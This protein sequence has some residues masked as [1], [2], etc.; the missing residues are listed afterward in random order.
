MRDFTQRRVAAACCIA[1]ALALAGC[2]DDGTAPGG[3]QGF[4][5]AIV[6]DDPTATSPSASG[7]LFAGS[8][9]SEA[10]L[11][12]GSITADLAVAISADGT[13][14]IELGP[15]AAL[16]LTAQAA[17]TTAIHSDAAVPAGSFNRIRLR[18][19][20]ASVE[21]LAG[22]TIGGITIVTD[23]SVSVNGG[24]DVEIIMTVP[25]FEV[26][27]DASVRTEV[28]LDLNSEL[29]ITEEAVQTGTA[30]EGDLEAAIEGDVRAVARSS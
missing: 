30:S 10:A 20:N 18:L 12:S 3:Q 13:T 11:Y 5:S 22:S 21:V 7:P 17:G 24:D 1:L 27:A 8:A 28:F 15:P 23:V 16:S 25:A 19:Q 26:A 29:W 2:D 14:W 9:A 6:T 4:A